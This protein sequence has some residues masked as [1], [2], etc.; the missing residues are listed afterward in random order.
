MFKLLILKRKVYFFHFFHFFHFKKQKTKTKNK[1]KK[2][3]QKQI[4]SKEVKIFLFFI[5]WI[6]RKVNEIFFHN[7]SHT[8]FNLIK[9]I[10][11][12][13]FFFIFKYFFQ[14]H[15]KIDF[16]LETFLTVNSNKSTEFEA[17]SIKEPIWEDNYFRKKKKREETK[18]IKKLKSVL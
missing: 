1:N 12:S 5:L 2:Q 8:N 4:L 9:F 16:S 7:F 15:R 14:N 18:K 10:L 3:K 6:F 17:F 13:F 11:I